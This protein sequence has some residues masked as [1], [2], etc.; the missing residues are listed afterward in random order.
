MLA[1]PAEKKLDLEGE[2]ADDDEVRARFDRVGRQDLRHFPVRPPFHGAVDHTERAAAVPH[3]IDV[4]EL[5]VDELR[6][7]LFE[8]LVELPPG[9]LLAGHAD[10]GADLHALDVLVEPWDAE[11][12]EV[13]VVLEHLEDVVAADEF[14]EDLFSEQDNNRGKVESL[15]PGG[16]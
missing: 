3:K 6:G 15:L 7:E 11:A 13:A 12:V 4:V 14:L 8:A 9:L 10:V 1:P 2:R 5:L 16:I